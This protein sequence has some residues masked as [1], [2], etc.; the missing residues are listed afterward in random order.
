MKKV[1][2]IQS[3][4]RAFDI[5]NCFNEDN[6]YLKLNDIS[7]ILNLNINT[8][9]GIVNTLLYYGYLE[10]D[11]IQNV[12]SLGYI[13]R[14]KNNL[15][16]LNDNYIFESETETFLTDLADKYTVTARLHLVKNFDII[17]LISKDPKASRY[18]FRV[19]DSVEFPLNATSSGK[20]ILYYSDEKILE[21]Y[22]EDIPKIKITENTITEKEK[23]ILE[24][25]SI[26]ENGY[27]MEFDEVGIGISSI[28]VPILSFSKLKYTISVSGP[29]AII[30]E[31]IKSLSKEMLEFAKKQRI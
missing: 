7:E 13:F 21:N 25:D 17:N 10:H 14:Q 19:K 8:T 24:F 23:L 18:I 22:L 1:K 31:N 12:Y 20:L 26:K 27:S 6:V 29:T 4:Q 9:R 11:E 28:A 30:K 3:I 5:I 16:K 2:L 15:L